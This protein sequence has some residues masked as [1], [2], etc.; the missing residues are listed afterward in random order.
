L[1][2]RQYPL[3]EGNQIILKIAI[4]LKVVFKNNYRMDS[5]ASAR[6]DK[7]TLNMAPRS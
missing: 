4:F 6:A 5:K 2:R 1:A 3:N 7:T